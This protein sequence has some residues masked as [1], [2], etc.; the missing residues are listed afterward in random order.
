MREIE[1]KLQRSSIRRWTI[2]RKAA[3]L[4]ALRRGAVTLEKASERYALS[5]EEL[6]T[7]ERD[8]EQYGVYGLRATRLQI[9]RSVSNSP[10][11]QKAVKE[12][13]GRRLKQ[14]EAENAELKQLV[15]D[16]GSKK[17]TPHL[18]RRNS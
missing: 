10:R 4:E 2:R 16:L 15:A 11:R 14:L 8:F 17:T 7:W 1:G 18:R 6:R 3:L 13:E 12:I 9:Y 5:V